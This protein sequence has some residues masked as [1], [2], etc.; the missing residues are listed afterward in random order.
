MKKPSRSARPCSE[1][2]RRSRHLLNRGLIIIATILLPLAGQGKDIRWH[3]AP[4]PWRAVF[5]ITGKP[6]IP[7]AGYFLTVPLCGIGDLDGKNVVVFDQTGRKLVTVAMGRSRDNA[8][9]ILAGS[10]RVKG[11]LYAYWGSRLMA[12]QAKGAFTP[13]LTVDIR[14]AIPNGNISTWEKSRRM[15]ETSHCL[16][17]IPIPR[18]ELA[19]NPIDSTDAIIMDFNGTLKSTVSQTWELFLV[20]DD[21][22]YLLID[23][24]PVIQRNGRHS[25]YENRYG[26]ER[27]KIILRKGY[28]P[29]RCVVIDV[30]GQQMAVLAR[31]ENAKRKYILP[32]DSFVQSGTT[33][34]EKVQA[35]DHGPCPVFSITQ[36]SYC[37]APGNTWTEILLRTRTG[38]PVQWKLKNGITGTGAELH[39]VVPGLTSLRLTTRCTTGGKTASGMI[40][41]NGIPPRRSWKKDAIYQKYASLITS[42]P[43]SEINDKTLLA[44]LDF[45]L[46]RERYGPTSIICRELL[47]RNIPTE[48][49]NNILLTLAR[50]SSNKGE[51]EKA[52]RKL[53]NRLPREQRWTPALEFIEF[54]LYRRVDPKAV[55][56]LLQQKESFFSA[57]PDILLL[58]AAEAH[59]LLGEPK[60][61]RAE[62]GRLRDH[63]ATD[64]RNAV[65]RSA[66]AEAA[67]LRDLR[68]NSFSQAEKD[69][70]DW[71][72]FTPA[73]MESGRYALMRTRLLLRYGWLDGALATLSNATR[74]ND[75]PAFLPEIEF[76]RAEILEIKGK[77][78]EA[79]SIYSHILKDYPNHP[80]AQKARQRLATP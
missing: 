17:I 33:R 13:G 52:Y 80:L 69:L 26:K 76:K 70:R 49:R 54:E 2:Y 55:Q 18:I 7:K 19:T 72:V 9:L 58:Y 32:A 36:L 10:T 67:Y 14:T 35:R 16:G 29:I 43:L 39:A 66:A 4:S 15:L 30:G 45:L 5:R 28:T 47:K 6:D 46:L 40:H 53:L 60:K 20:S 62:I 51:A 25:A 48:R 77:K 11:K 75:L 79:Q 61:A 27:K 1:R 74:L 42:V 3:H 34:I 31:Y 73:A 65:V 8:A 41:F 23:H 71:A 59:L 38:D 21:A 78:A 24:K 68:L 44:Y 12:P 63:I 50:T 64:P 56:Q 22:G 57:T 37:A